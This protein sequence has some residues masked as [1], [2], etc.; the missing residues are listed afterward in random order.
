MLRYALPATLI[1]GGFVVALV[2]SFEQPSGIVP[3]TERPAVTGAGPNASSGGSVASVTSE[4]SQ[5]QSE[6]NAMMGALRS[7]A[8]RQLQ[9]FQDA[10]TGP[11]APRPAPPAAAP[12]AS[13]VAS[14]PVAPAPAPQ[15]ANP[16][17]ATAPRLPARN[18]SV[19]AAPAS[20][21]ATRPVAPAAEPGA[22]AAPANVPPRPTSPPAPRQFAA[23]V[24]AQH[25]EMP[26]MQSWVRP[27]VV[28]P[29]PPKVARAAPAPPAVTQLVSADQALQS[30]DPVG[31]RALLEAAETSVVFAP[32]AG[33]SRGNSVA[34]AQITAALRPAN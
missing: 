5:L 33:D 12:P 21:T 19:A 6:V 17:V 11:K 2:A 14:P 32:A 23:V 31:A 7:G 22:L 24:P 8:A 3:R 28:Q 13:Q 29:P 18:R 30:N 4:Q 16:P 20:Q 25:P 10:L 9:E 15:A 1:V 27:V 34:A 26:P